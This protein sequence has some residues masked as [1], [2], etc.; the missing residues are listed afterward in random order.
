MQRISG[1][2]TRIAG[3]QQ[4]LVV[5][6]VAQPPAYVTVKSAAGGV[7][8]EPVVVV[9]A[10]SGSA[11][12]APIAVGDSASTALGTPVSINVLANDSDP[13]GNVPLTIANLTQP[14]TGTG[15]VTTSGVSVTYTPPAGLTGPLA[16]PTAVPAAN[17]R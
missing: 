14:A 9:G 4:R 8:T 3:S 15:S 12:Q 5:G 11:N 17:D 16:P 7:D 6:E 2:L 10:P 1:A 13:G